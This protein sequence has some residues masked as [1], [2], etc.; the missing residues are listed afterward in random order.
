MLH[1]EE[2]WGIKPSFPGPPLRTHY[3]V[4]ACGVHLSELPTEVVLEGDL[5]LRGRTT[6]L[7]FFQKALREIIWSMALSAGHCR[8]LQAV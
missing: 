5:L 4:M 7:F 6:L 1:V 2:E 8:C 3:T